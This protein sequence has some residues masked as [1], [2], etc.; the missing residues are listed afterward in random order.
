MI[1][2]AGF[3]FLCSPGYR[4]HSGDGTLARVADTMRGD[5]DGFR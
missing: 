4:N 3:T 1:A 5:R 2:I